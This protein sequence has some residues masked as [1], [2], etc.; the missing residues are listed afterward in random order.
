MSS[1]DVSLLHVRACEL[2]HARGDVPEDG[3]GIDG[4][5]TDEFPDL[6][7]DQKW[8]VAINADDVEREYRVTENHTMT[9]DP[10]RVHFWYDTDHVVP[11]AIGNPYGG[12]ALVS[13]DEFPR[14]TEDQIIASVEAVLVEAGELDEPVVY[15]VGEVAD[16]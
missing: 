3:S 6:N 13:G 10:F 11:A 1:D 15:E 7:T 8:F 5:W 2:A 12:Q 4:I 14:T 16:E 9:I